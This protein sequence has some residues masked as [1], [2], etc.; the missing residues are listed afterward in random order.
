MSSNLAR[1]SPRA[2]ARKIRRRRSPRRAASDRA[3][4]R[5]ERGEVEPLRGGEALQRLAQHLAP[6]AER[7]LGRR[8]QEPRVARLGFV[9]RDQ[10]DDAGGHLRRR[11]ERGGGDVEQEPRARAPAR[12]HREPAV[13]GALGR[14]WRRCAAPPRAGTSA[15]AD[16]RTAATARPRASAS[17]APSRRCRAGWRRCVSARRPPRRAASRRR[18]RARRRR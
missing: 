15:S 8:R 11:G 6:L 7:G 18:G 3:P 14:A 13:V 9:A 5:R 16:H 17:A 12:Q 2:P 10:F 1:P 4:R